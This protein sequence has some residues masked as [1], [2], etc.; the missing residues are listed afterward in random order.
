MKI[1]GFQA[2]HDV[3]YCILENGIPII[4]E[5]L[6]RFTREKEP[7]GDGLEMFFDM[8]PNYIKDDQ[9]DY[10]FAY[11]GLGYERGTYDQKSRDFNKMMD[12]VKRCNSEFYRIGHHQS[13]AANA[14]YSSNFDEAL[15]LTIDGGG[16]EK[17]NTEDWINDTKQLE[18]IGEYASFRSGNHTCGNGVVA[19]TLWEGKQNKMHRIKAFNNFRINI[20]NFWNVCL[21]QIFGLKC[22]GGKGQGGNQAGTIMGMAPLGDGN[23]KYKEL[24]NKSCFSIFKDEFLKL[25]GGGVY[26]RDM[27]SYLGGVT[28]LLKKVANKSEQDKF[29]VAMGLQMATEFMIR[30]VLSEFIKNHPYKN[31]CVSG[32]VSLNAVSMGKIYDW[33]P[34]IENVYCDPVP[35][36]G[37]LSLGSARYVWHHVLDNPR[38]KRKGNSSPYLGRQYSLEE[39]EKAINKFK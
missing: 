33:F 8:Q 19:V 16:K 27:Y 35:Y 7:H 23:V 22:G 17:A 5:E 21:V 2:G 11:G 24:G 34:S 12:I 3:S 29:N 13:H 39:I 31:L 36:D 14:F 1:I 26:F 38:I 4:H 25:Y 9:N 32:G 20:G 30:Q 6:E 28:H 10:C 15:I 37:G 18:Q